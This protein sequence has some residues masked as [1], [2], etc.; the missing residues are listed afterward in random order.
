[1]FPYTFPNALND[2]YFGYINMAE[3]ASLLFVRTRMSIKFTPKMV[4]M[5]N[6]MFLFYLNSYLY[7]ASVQFFYLVL[8]ATVAV[9]VFFMLEYEYEAINNWNPF[10]I[11]TPRYMNPRA[12]YQLVLDDSSFGTGFYLWHT[13]MPVRPR[14]TFTIYEQARYDTLSE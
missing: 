12:A 4:T 6:L 8:S 1:M 14:E 13:F 11:Y 9:F 7:A 10:D 2:M 5:L 3:F